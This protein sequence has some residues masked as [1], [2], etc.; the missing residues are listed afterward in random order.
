MVEV[1][2]D[3]CPPLKNSAYRLLRHPIFIDLDV[4]EQAK[5]YGCSKRLGL[6]LSHLTSNGRTTVS[7]R[8]SD[9]INRGWLRTPLGG[10]GGMHY[11]LWW[12]PAGSPVTE[13][14]GLPVGSILVKAIRHHDN[15]ATLAADDFVPLT[16][17]DIIG[18]DFNEFPWTNKQI[19]FVRNEKPVRI[20][21]GNPVSGKTTALWKSVTE[22]DH[23]KVLYLTWS[24]KLAEAASD[25]LLTF[26][27][28]GS[29]IVT[30]NF[31]SFVSQILG[32][33]IP[34]IDMATVQ[35]SFKSLLPTLDPRELG[36]W[37]IQNVRE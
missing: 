31:G 10:G 23:Q 6:V 14:K 8:C 1:V 4:Y 21:I 11:Y 18:N 33:D 15:H 19:D 25:Y 37:R 30:L 2:L 5:L 17:Q 28:A 36:Y 9:S 35:R 13:G 3:K 29:E 22:R 26:A 20:L 7:K 34:R 24:R 32:R 12:S 27:P 16:I